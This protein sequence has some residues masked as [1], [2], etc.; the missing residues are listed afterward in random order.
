MDHTSKYYQYYHCNND[1]KSYMK[2]KH[3]L[4]YRLQTMLGQMKNIPFLSIILTI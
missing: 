2:L 3:E 1:K 4:N